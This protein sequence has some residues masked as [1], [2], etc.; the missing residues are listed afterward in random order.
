MGDVAFFQTESSVRGQ[1]LQ[2]S[3]GSSDE[4]VQAHHFI[5]GGQQAVA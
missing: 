1:V 2:V 5:A 4:I 3:P